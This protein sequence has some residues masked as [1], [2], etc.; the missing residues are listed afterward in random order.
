MCC[1][2]ML[3]IIYVMCY[4]TDLLHHNSCYI[5]CL[6]WYINRAMLVQFERLPIVQANIILIVSFLF[7]MK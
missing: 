3:Y 2:I 7:L 6:V 4:T 5:I 1:S